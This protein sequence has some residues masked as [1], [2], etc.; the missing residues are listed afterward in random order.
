MNNLVKLND[1]NIFITILSLQ[2]AIIAFFFLNNINIHIS[3]LPEILSIIFL[4]FIPGFLVIRFLKIKDINPLEFIMYDLGLSI[5]FLMFVGFMMNLIYPLL[6]IKNP[7]TFLNVFFTINSIIIIMLILTFIKTNMFDEPIFLKKDAFKCPAFYFFLILPFISIIGTYSMNIFNINMILMVLFGLIA[8]VPIFIAW[9]KF[10][11]KN[12]YPFATFMVSLS[13]LFS[14]SLISFYIWGYDIQNEYYLSKLV[15]TNSLWDPKVSLAS[16]SMLSIVFLAPILSIFSGIKLVWIYK[17]VYPFI[18]AF[19]PLALY[20]IFQK[21]TNS[22]I[23]FFSSFFFMSFFVFFHEMLQLARQEIAELFLVLILLLFLNENIMKMKKSIMLL[24]FAS[25]LIV[26]HYGISYIFIGLLLGTYIFTYA[27]QRKAILFKKEFFN[28]DS[29]SHNKFISSSILLF[30]VVLAISWYSYT[31]Q[32]TNFSVVIKLISNISSSLNDLMNPQSAQGYAIIVSGTATKIGVYSKFLQI[33]SQV[34]IVIGVICVFFNYMKINLKTEYLGITLGSLTLCFLAIFTP[35]LAS[36]LNTSRL[37]QISL[38]FLSVF[39]IIGGLAILKIISRSRLS[40]N[41][42]LKILSIFL[43]IILLFNTGFANQI[44][45]EPTSISLT[46]T[47]DYP[48]FNQKEVYGSNWIFTY[49][50]NGNIYADNYRSLLLQSD[51]ISVKTLD[52]LNS[53]PRNTYLYLGNANIK[54]NTIAVRE[55]SGVTHKIVYINSNMFTNGS[56]QIYDNSG[57]KIFFKR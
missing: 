35:Y 55:R 9:D 3:P 28:K 7:L 56:N 4:L 33:L 36:A 1:K 43:A 38:I 49:S 50:N 17:V 8:L 24:I 54:N 23:A 31:A 26:S 6:G 41:K 25:A 48:Q 21:Q 37:Y 53:L 34:F 46:N 16:N 20:K 29:I 44:F 45:N 39:C 52:Y 30:L 57:S 19:V 2:I 15:I 27:Y 10:I 14:S 22:K 51:F 42:S 11:P 18:F 13:L 32:S 40:F 5:A 47:V 12:L